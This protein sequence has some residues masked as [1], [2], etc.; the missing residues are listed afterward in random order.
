MTSE[1]KKR[2]FDFHKDYYAFELERKDKLLQQVGLALGIL[3]VI[4]NLFAFFL[5]DFQFVEFREVHLLFYFF[6]SFGFLFTAISI[7][8][9]TKTLIHRF[10]YETIPTP[11]EIQDALNECDEYNTKVEKAEAL[12]TEEVFYENLIKQYSEAT[13]RNHL[14][15][16]ARYSNV[17]TS[18]RFSLIGLI[19]LI[20]SFPGYQVL[21]KE[22]S[23]K[24]STT[25]IKEEVKVRIMSEDKD[26]Q[27]NQQQTS[28]QP[29]ERPQWPQGRIIKEADEKGQNKQTFNEQK[30]K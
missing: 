12:D 15:N 22:F 30:D 6:F 18:L 20:C 1:F 3:T 26:N 7:I 2:Q 17:F 14:S 11:K 23:I 4:G 13:H 5:R 8:Y 24:P 10:Y 19:L 28:N 29:V 21:K 9:L 25:E 16:L 27:S